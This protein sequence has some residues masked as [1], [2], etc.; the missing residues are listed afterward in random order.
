MAGGKPRRHV[1]SARSAGLA[2]FFVALTPA[3]LSPA[4]P[5]LS[6]TLAARFPAIRARLESPVRFESAS[7]QQ[8]VRRISGMRALLPPPSQPA[9]VAT[10][11]A[12]RGG[13]AP[14]TV[15]RVIVSFPALAADAVVAEGEGVRVVL[16]PLSTRAARAEA[17]GAAVAYRDVYPETDALHVAQPDWTEEYLHLRTPEAPRR[18]EYE[19]VEAAGATRV[20]LD[21]GQ[22]RFVDDSGRGLVALAPVVVD[23]IGR[24]SATAAR[25]RLDEQST[26][27]RLTLQLDSTGLAYPLLVDPT[28][29]TTGSLSAARTYPIGILLQTGQVLVMGSAATSELYDPTTGIWTPAGAGW[30]ARGFH[31]ATLL[32][33]GRVLACGGANGPTFADCRTYDP[34]GNTW[35]P[36]ASMTGPRQRF[37][38]TLLA[39]GRVLAAGGESAINVP[40]SSAEV[41]DPPS[42]LWTATGS[43]LNAHRS[44][45]ATLLAN[46]KVLV[47][48]GVTLP[49]PSTTRVS[50]VWDPASG[51][52]TRVGDLSTAR[53]QLS[54][55][56][57]PNGKVLAAGG[58]LFAINAAEL[59]DPATNLWT[60]T[61]N[62]LAVRTEH[63]ATL[64]PNGRVLVAGG[65]NGSARAT[66]EYYDPGT[67]LWTPGPSMTFAR[68]Q[69][70]A[71]MLPDGRVLVSGGWNGAV[72]STAE[73]L[74]TDAPFWTAGPNLA[75]SRREA[76]LTLLKDGKV[77]AVGGVGL[78][79]AEVYDPGTGAWTPTA[80]SLS[81]QR[82]RHTATLL[83]DGR[84]LVAGTVQSV[85]AG[86]TAEIYDPSSNSWSPTASMGVDRDWHTASLLHCGEVLV[87]GGDSSGGTQTAQRYNPK[88]KTWRPT[89]S[90]VTGRWKHTATLLADGRVLVTG[91]WNGGQLASA[92]LYD[93][94]SETWTVTAGPMT[95]GRYHH[96]ATLLPNG[97]VLITG[98]FN[99]SSAELFNPTTGIF[100]AAGSS[101]ALLGY[102][103]SAT[104]LPN[105][106]VLAVGG[107]FD[108]ARSSVYDP[109]EGSWTAGPLV[110]PDRD[111]H[112]AVLLL[113][114]RVLVVGGDG[115][116][117]DSSALYDVGRG[118]MPAWRPSL[119]TA[120]DPLLRASA[121]NVTGSGFQGLGEGSTGLGYM[122]SATNYPLV[123][124]RRLDNEQVRWL[125]VEPAVGWSATSFRSTAVNGFPN[126]PALATVFTNGIP[127]VS[128]AVMVECPPPT[129]DIP[130]TDASVCAGGSAVFSVTATAPGN[131]CPS[132]RWRRNG[133]LLAEAAP[134]S[135]V[136]TPTLTVSPATPAEA[137]SYTVEVSLACS[138]TVVTS[139]V[140][141]LTVSTSM[142]AVDASISGP[143]SVCTTCLGGVASEVHI[144]GGAVTHQWGYRTTSGGTI[145]DIP[146][147]TS[148]TYVLNGADFPAEGN[149]FLVVRVTPACGAATT[150]DEVPVTVANTV[151][152]AN[153][154][155]F[156]TVTS[157][158]SRNV[159]EWVYPAAFNKVRIRYTSG[160]PCAYPANG[161]TDGS[162]LMDLVGLA[163]ERD[164]IA[165][166]PV[167]N[168]TTYCYTIF[169]D[170]TGGGVWST[171]RTNSGTP[172]PTGGP[173]KW[174]FHSGMFSTTAPTVGSAGIIATNN[175]NAVHAMTR[176]LAGGE[177]PAGWKPVRLGG[178]VQNRSPIVPIDVGSSNP[179]AFLGA[180]DGRVYAIDATTG[181]AA[182]SPWPAPASVGGLVQAAPAGVF[183]DF[184]GSF[185]YLLVGTRVANAD[186]VFK[187][188]DPADG[189]PLATFDNGGAGNGIGIISGMAAVDA[190]TSRVYFTSAVR[191]G[192]SAN[193]L[194]CL[195]LGPSGSVFALVW[196]R[197]DLGSIESAPVLRGGRVYV[198][199]TNG[200]GTLYSINAATG[201]SGDDRM[202]VHGDGPVKGFV[203]PDRNSPTGDLYFAANTR[204]W[205]VTEIGSV[206]A[207]KFGAGITLPDGAVPST[208]LFHPGSHYVY[209]G[210]NL[211]RFL[212]I[213]SLT[214]S[215]ADAAVK[216]GASPFTL[217]APSLDIG[218]G[219][220]HIGSEPGTFFAIEVPLPACVIS[221]AGKPAGTPCSS[222]S[223][224]LCTEIC[225]SSTAGSCSDGGGG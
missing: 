170:T 205:G 179:V 37:T 57:L 110:A 118:E 75:A 40:V 103:S 100:T 212:Q 188:F 45:S 207:N 128:G 95:I 224:S 132:Y 195:Q 209:V 193:T 145:T 25:W 39:D 14:T 225:A 115:A 4:P 185:D 41:Y 106:R 215:F 165:H 177:W 218:Y 77:L 32:R 88:T 153:E 211:G 169:V 167:G 91:G 186:N 19:I 73:L 203:F 114:G 171:G 168:G 5:S 93:P 166:D 79:S 12:L 3:G 63:S 55:T 36:A 125:P 21:N 150:S 129:I 222:S 17:E 1:R 33:S 97:N 46:G 151:G 15:D 16:A 219:L 190:A 192:G 160:L 155:P 52:W 210:D 189:T 141:T 11:A 104:L 164:S 80:N 223:V 181:A 182:A 180:Q 42:N 200:G 59:F 126:G 154:V 201:S 51:T 175:D 146:F 183:T 90:L 204:V 194:W 178:A 47:A 156:V 69:H 27:R 148:P 62:L 60:A 136:T 96:L 99:T 24:R 217:G 101:P 102:G 65:L 213:D 191:A 158:D 28:W 174:A 133:V 10:R 112:A 13:A 23:S 147:A 94:A 26:P 199:S 216:L 163:G 82:W 61:A 162:F 85:I 81:A 111:T 184:F 49:G 159:L 86:R 157:R 187:A 50:E 135:G 43:M 198:G 89:G 31:A 143:A 71:T 108:P 149:Y 72:L 84:V 140:A 109:G 74:D 196:A 172:F 66:T 122:H 214:G 142:G 206:L 8:G 123:Q 202:Y 29:I 119:A 20:F 98:G 138:S 127:G 173:L 58:G 197:D 2:V 9:A 68:Y 76:S 105:G 7:W 38:L 34:V 35:S 176:G 124:L 67:G 53:G 220:V 113:D 70:A 130:P 54:A 6:E 87:V 30:A 44:H 116:A 152:P 120:T 64:L 161:D 137:G 83:G 78:D 134:F 221:C 208:L 56:L 92:E 107:F 117:D 144:G 121:L 18:F 48:G 139:A 131:D 22:V